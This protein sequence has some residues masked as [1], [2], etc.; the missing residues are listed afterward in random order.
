MRSAS[1]GFYPKGHSRNGQGLILIS[2]CQRY[3]NCYTRAAVSMDVSAEALN[4]VV[5]GGCDGPCDPQDNFCRYCG[6]SLVEKTQLPSFQRARLLPAIRTPSVPAT[7]AKGAAFVAA[8][9]IAEIVV[10]RVAR[11]VL[12]GGSNGAKKGELVP[13]KTERK[14]ETLQSTEVVSETVLVRQTRIRR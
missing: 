12:G 14:P 1:C 5:C 7:V 10:R 8:G 11:N 9:K 6:F 4:A 2:G 3:V 13:A